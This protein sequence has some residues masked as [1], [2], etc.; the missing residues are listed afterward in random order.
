[1]FDTNTFYPVES[2]SKSCKKKEEAR[3]GAFSVERRK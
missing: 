1:M 3:K 2:K